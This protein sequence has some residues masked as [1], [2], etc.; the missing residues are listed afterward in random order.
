MGSGGGFGIYGYFYSP[1]L[2]DFRAYMTRRNKLVLI[3]TLHETFV[4]TPDDPE[5]FIAAVQ[6]KGRV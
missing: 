6:Q 2:K 5:G 4:L 1:N 3:R